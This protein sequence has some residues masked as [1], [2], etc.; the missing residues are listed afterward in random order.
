M[1]YWNFNCTAG[2][3]IRQNRDKGAAFMAVQHRIDNMTAIGAQHTTVVTH[4][5]ASGA[6]NK[7]VNHLRSGFTKPAVL[8]V[9]AY[10]PNHV[11]TFIVFCYQAWALYVRLVQFVL[12]GCE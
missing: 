9:L 10:S 7:P 1:M 8:A 2:E 12:E 5:F 6:L 3:D 4:R 11:V